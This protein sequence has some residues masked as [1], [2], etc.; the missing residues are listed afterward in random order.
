MRNLKLKEIKSKSPGFFNLSGGYNMETKPNS[1]KT[2]NK[3]TAAIIDYINFNGGHANRINTQGQVRK[4]LISFAFGRSMDKMAYIPSMTK[5]C[6][7]DINA[8]IK[9]KPVSIE[10]NIGHNKLSKLQIKSRKGLL[11][12]MDWFMSHEIC[13]RL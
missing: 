10:I 12:L 8:F 9:G 6:I 5:R 11:R 7:A 1:D 3:L 13:P 4:E 2:S